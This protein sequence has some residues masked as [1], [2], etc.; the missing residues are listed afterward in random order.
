MKAADKLQLLAQQAA[1]F[2]KHWASGKTFPGPE[3][4]STG[5]PRA[6]LDL[7]VFHKLHTALP[8]QQA[9]RGFN[10]L[11]EGFV[12]W[13]EVRVS[14]V[15]EIQEALGLCPGSLELA[16]FVKDLLEL[17]HREKQ[18][19]SLEFL[20]E[21]NLGEI[22]Q[23]LKRF[24]GLDP[25][26]TELLLRVRKEHPV[27]P[28]NHAMEL[29]L[30]RLGIL[31]KGETRS[32]N[33]KSLHELVDPARHLLLHHYLLNHAVEVCPP[34]ENALE[35]PTCGIRQMCAF[36]ARNG[37]KPPRS[38]EKAE[39]PTVLAKQGASKPPGAKPTKPRAGK[40]APQIKPHT[41]AARKPLK[42]V[43]R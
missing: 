16:V 42:K 3:G 34:D 30:T 5:Y 37:K 39:R 1:S 17:I 32:K 21:K 27:V 22:R 40:S 26:T 25:S 38:K 12:D 23:Y 7:I 15:R 13:N 2:G 29:V 19:V 31:R 6:F 9:L 28:L 11:K 8:A 35:C 36:Y 43:A 33:E 41:G 4:D 24:R 10:E 20:A 18:D 14:A